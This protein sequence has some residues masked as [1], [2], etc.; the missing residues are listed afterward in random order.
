MQLSGN[1]LTADEFVDL[2]ARDLAWR[3]A[4]D[5]PDI[6]TIRLEDADDM[7]SLRRYLENA[8]TFTLDWLQ[9]RYVNLAA[10][11]VAHS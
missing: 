7:F 6:A 1:D 5:R 2:R 9:E 10:N 3:K 4:L 8:L 11:D